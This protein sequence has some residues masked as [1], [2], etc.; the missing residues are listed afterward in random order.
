M[1]RAR[2]LLTNTDMLMKEVAVA[3]GF[4][5]AD[6]MGRTFQRIEEISPKEFRQ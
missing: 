6:N 2:R 3:A 4:S 5:N 1:E